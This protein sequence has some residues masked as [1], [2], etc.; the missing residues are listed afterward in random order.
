MPDNTTN[1]KHQTE[2]DSTLFSKAQLTEQEQDLF[3]SRLADENYIR[4]EDDVSRLPRTDKPN[5]TLDRD[6][7][8]FIRHLVRLGPKS[9]AGERWVWKSDAEVADELGMSRTQLKRIRESGVTEGFLEYK[10]DIRP[11]DGRRTTFYRANLAAVYARVA[12]NELARAEAMLAKPRLPE[13]Q[14]RYFTERR[15]MFRD[16][17]ALA[18]RVFADAA[19]RDDD[20]QVDDFNP[21]ASL[22]PDVDTGPV[23]T[24]DR[25]DNIEDDFDDFDDDFDNDA[26][27]ND[28]DSVN[29]TSDGIECLNQRFN[30]SELTHLTR[31]H[32]KGTSQE[33]TLQVASVEKSPEAERQ[34]GETQ[35]QR[36]SASATKLDTPIS[37]EDFAS[38]V[39]DAGETSISEAIADGFSEM[40]ITSLANHYL[41]RLGVKKEPD[42]TNAATAKLRPLFEAYASQSVDATGKAA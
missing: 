22:D 6:L 42:T 36:A 5:R 39:G 33:S 24:D 29:D 37:S 35:K 16:G 40:A 21:E 11:T 9:H 12:E 32:H 18:R 10:R 13:N 25:Q 26:R 31:V 3:T 14:L 41:K 2:F 1:I 4:L 15:D 19:A 8:A 23:P 17:V 30:V 27:V 7:G 28:V 34:I 20:E 38:L